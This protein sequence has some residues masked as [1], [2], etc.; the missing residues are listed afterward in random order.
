MSNDPKKKINITLPP[1]SDEIHFGEKLEAVLGSERA[2]EAL[3]LPTTGGFKKDISL[4][5]QAFGRGVMVACGCERAFNSHNH[6]YFS[7]L[8][9]ISSPQDM[10][11]SSAKNG[12]HGFGISDHGSMGG[13][14]KAGYAAKK[15]QTARLHD[16]RLVNFEEISFQTSKPHQLAVLFEDKELSK[17]D[18][19]PY[20]P[21]IGR[22]HV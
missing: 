21:E 16:G 3:G 9:G 6:T 2:T 19:N 10:V 15:W 12:W 7:V 1:S 11:S 17:P 8:D 20:T 13:N 5:E 22:A 4:K 18:W 14:L